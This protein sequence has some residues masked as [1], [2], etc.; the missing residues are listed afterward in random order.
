[1]KAWPGELIGKKSETGN[2][3]RPA[4]AGRHEGFN[5]DSKTVPGFRAINADWA[6][7]RIDPRWIDSG[8]IV[9]SARLRVVPTGSIEA[10]DGQA[11]AGRDIG[12]RVECVVPS[13]VMVGRV[14]GSQWQRRQ[15]RVL[16]LKGSL[17]GAGGAIKQRG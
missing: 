17:A 6:C 13:M 10:L 5:P 12:D 15:D 7:H 4:K 11:V 2:D 8:N 9:R 16:P 3:R 1:M 14:N